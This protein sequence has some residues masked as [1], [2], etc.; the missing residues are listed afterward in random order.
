MQTKQEM[1]I[2]IEK[3]KRF[4]LSGSG[5]ISDK[6]LASEVQTVPLQRGQLYNL[7]D[8]KWIGSKPRSHDSPERTGYN[9]VEIKKPTQRR[10]TVE[11]VLKRVE[12]PEEARK[13]VIK[14]LNKAKRIEN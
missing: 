3:R 9:I 10:G 14:I 5:K 2:Q 6:I 13:E 7:S 4:G 12:T 8:T 11:K 1:A